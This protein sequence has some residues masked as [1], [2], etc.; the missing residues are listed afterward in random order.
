VGR[1]LRDIGRKNLIYSLMQQGS[2]KKTSWMPKTSENFNFHII[3]LMEVEMNSW[4]I[5]MIMD[6]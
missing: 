3:K 4:S 2:T 1:T 5:Y 6:Y